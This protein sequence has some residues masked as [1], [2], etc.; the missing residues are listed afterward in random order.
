MAAVIGQL[1]ATSD[2]VIDGILHLSA[3]GDR[4]E[5]KVPKSTHH[6]SSIV[7]AVFAVLPTVAVYRHQT[8]RQQSPVLSS[9]CSPPLD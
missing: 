9:L 7:Y 4:G 5:K 1:P 3:D 2:G 8:S 6:A